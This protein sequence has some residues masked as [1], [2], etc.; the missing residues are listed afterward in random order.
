MLKEI[1]NRNS[2]CKISFRTDTQKAET[3]NFYLHGLNSFVRGPDPVLQLLLLK[4]SLDERGYHNTATATVQPPSP[5][6]LYLIFS[7]VAYFIFHAMTITTCL[8]AIERHLLQSS[9]SSPQWNQV[10]RYLSIYHNENLPKRIEDLRNTKKCQILK[11][12]RNGPRVYK[13]SPNLVT[14]I[15]P[16]L[17]GGKITIHFRIKCQLTNKDSFL[18]CSQFTH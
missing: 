10:A 5:A 4:C 14:L 15:L 3:K 17:R 18:K 16:L 6:S 9:M 2:R 7:I 11:T 13:I 12:V 8:L 1:S